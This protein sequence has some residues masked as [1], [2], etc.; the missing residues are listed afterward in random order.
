MVVAI[1]IINETILN[2]LRPSK[3]S[4]LHALLPQRRKLRLSLTSG[5]TIVNRGDQNP[6]LQATRWM[7]SLFHFI[8]SCPELEIDCAIFWTQ[9]KSKSEAEEYCR[10]TGRTRV[11]RKLINILL[12]DLLVC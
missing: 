6:G 1:S 11:E 9:N 2:K 7:S 5:C 8:T 10:P 3:S 12:I 4:P